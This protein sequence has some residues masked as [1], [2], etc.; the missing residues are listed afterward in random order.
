MNIGKAIAIFLQIE[1]DKHTD[2]EK[3]LAIHMVLQ[4]PTL[5]GITKDS[6]LS[7]AKYLYGICYETEDEQ[8]G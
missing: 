5:N 4:M 8:D 3:A 2:E 7:V 6:L 1:S